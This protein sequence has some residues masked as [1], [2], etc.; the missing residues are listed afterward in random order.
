MYKRLPTEA[1]EL[2]HDVE[3]SPRGCRVVVV[4]QHGQR[5]PADGRGKRPRDNRRR[6]RC[7]EQPGQARGVGRRGAPRLAPRG[8]AAD[9]G[10]ARPH[11]CM[12]K[13]V[14]VAS[15]RAVLRYMDIRSGA[16]ARAHVRT[17]FQ[18]VLGEPVRVASPIDLYRPK[19]KLFML[20]SHKS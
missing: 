10:D 8:V 11:S 19:A 5:P 16:R 15:E 3:H 20:H 1:Q 12:F 13:M 2:S 14:V 18:K 9:A 17:F 7:R 4:P 6:R